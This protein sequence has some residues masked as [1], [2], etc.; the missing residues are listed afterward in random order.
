VRRLTK[1]VD[2]IEGTNLKIIDVGSDHAY[3]G[4]K[5][6]AQNRLH[7]I[8]CTD[9]K[10]KP[11]KVSEENLKKLDITNKR[12]VLT[13]GLKGLNENVDYVVI[14]GMGGHNIADILEANKGV[15]SNKYLLQPNYD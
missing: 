10:K 3:V 13:D 14:A 6:F 2:L 15:I 11:L 7:T 1:I 5:L 8:I 12:F 4:A 9:N